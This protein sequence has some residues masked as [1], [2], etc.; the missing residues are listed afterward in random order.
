M[1]LLGKI[2]LIC[3]LLMGTYGCE[4]TQDEPSLIGTVWGGVMPASI[5]FVSSDDCFIMYSKQAIHCTYSLKNGIGYITL[6]DTKHTLTWNGQVIY[7]VAKKYQVTIPSND[8][9]GLENLE[10]GDKTLLMRYSPEQVLDTFQLELFYN[11]IARY[12]K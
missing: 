12:N 10:S 2:L 8:I 4:K 7:T 6:D 9:M 3:S 11:L 5:C 1:K